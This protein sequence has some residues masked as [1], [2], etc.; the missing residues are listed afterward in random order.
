MKQKKINILNKNLKNPISC[1]TSYS[2]STAKI[3]D[4]IVDM[5][6]VG[7]SLGTT[8]YGMRNTQGVSIDMMIQHGI[9]VKKNIKKSLTIIDMPYK[10][11]DNKKIANINAKKL[12]SKTKVDF[13]KLE[14]NE[15]KIHIVKFLS[16]KNFNIIAHIGVMPQTYNNFNKIKIKGRTKTEYNNLLKLAIELE[17]AGAKLL[18]LECVTENLAKRITSLVDIPTIGIGASKH[19]DGQVLVFDDLINLSANNKYPKFV[20]N[21]LNVNVL[22]KKAVRN[23]V[24]EV[25]NKTFPSKKYTY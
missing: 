7:D 21:Y 14:V 3:L 24:K 10:T 12:I 9:A 18:L 13:L 22:I 23:F 17:K 15:S 6:L 19:C 20:K 4:G 2:A 5:V 16:E 25:K 1:L 11:Y 8:L